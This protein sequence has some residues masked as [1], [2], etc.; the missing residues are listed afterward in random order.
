LA[1]CLELLLLPLLPWLLLVPLL[2]LLLLAVLLLYCHMC[3]LSCPVQ[4][5][6]T[7]F[8]TEATLEY[9]SGN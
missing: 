2:L 1:A 9:S 8:C 5:L 6:L 7:F 3:V 4:A